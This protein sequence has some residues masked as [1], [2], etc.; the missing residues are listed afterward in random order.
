MV[1]CYAIF[2]SMCKHYTDQKHVIL[3]NA[4]WS[5]L[6]AKKEVISTKQL[7]EIIIVWRVLLL[8]STNSKKQW[9]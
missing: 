8:H 3:G 2:S 6:S 1:R 5:V 4:P 9:V 7:S